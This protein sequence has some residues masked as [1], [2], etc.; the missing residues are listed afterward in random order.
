MLFFSHI[1]I[2]R[3][4]LSKI[5]SSPHVIM[6]RNSHVD[7]FHFLTVKNKKRSE[8]INVQ[9][10]IRN[11]YSTCTIQTHFYPNT[12]TTHAFVVQNH[13]AAELNKKEKVFK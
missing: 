11:F 10:V 12:T 3:V 13:S 9:I 7:I 6:V 1:K 5:T 8:N 2:I 4:L